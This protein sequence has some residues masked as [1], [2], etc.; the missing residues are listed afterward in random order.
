MSDTD[1][2]PMDLD[3]LTDDQ[4]MNLTP[5]EIDGLG[6][7]ENGDG[8][9]QL[10]DDDDASID[11]ADD[12]APDSGEEDSADEQPDESA[13]D[14]DGDG[15]QGTADED[16]PQGQDTSESADE[17]PAP[18]SADKDEKPKEPDAGEKK[19]TDKEL[20]AAEAAQS[21][22]ENAAA[23]DFFKK[24]SAPFK[25]NG[26][27]MQVRSA[28]DVI[29]LMQMGI[30]YSRNMQLMKPMKAMDAMLKTHGLNDPAKISY[31]IDVK[32]GKPEA[33]MKLLKDN[34]IDPLDLNTADDAPTYRQSNYQQDPKDQDFQE[35][36]DNTMARPG[37]R[38]LIADVNAMWD[39]KSKEALREEPAIFDNLL[40]QKDSGV[41][42]Q[43]KTELEYQRS[44][45]FLNNVPFLQA[46][47]QVSQAME[48]AGVFAPKI[49][50]G[51]VSPAPLATGSRRKAASKPKTVQPNP[52]SSASQ[53]RTVPSNG[54]SQNEPD[55]S[56]MT[57][58]EFM[59]LGEPT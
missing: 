19:P 7:Q 10:E 28:E 49:Q 39:D 23:V 53:P 41:Y 25:A 21:T 34:N 47:H 4:V 17:S 56:S 33:I 1:R 32:N 20:K 18:E 3:T 12:D 58:A 46:Y 26:K 24:V 50:E 13:D 29:R 54:T 27:E 9:G 40:A 38:E 51:Q 48:K 22:A 2:G 11:D 5:E 8:D 16:E 37:G 6:S 42:E 57:D 35:A 36:I 52:P 15:D 14:E 45:N 43:V 59:K 55:Y 31:L 44:L 30:D